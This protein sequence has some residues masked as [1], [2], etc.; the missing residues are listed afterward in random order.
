MLDAGALAADVLLLGDEP[1][2]KDQ[3]RWS[4]LAV[5]GVDGRS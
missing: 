4:R 3:R 2:T 1:D 5:Y